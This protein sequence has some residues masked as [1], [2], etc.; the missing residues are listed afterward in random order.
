MSPRS[1]PSGARDC[2]CS[3]TYVA[4]TL[5]GPWASVTSQTKPPALPA[6]VY[7]L[8]GGGDVAVSAKLHGD[9]V[10]GHLCAFGAEELVST[11]LWFCAGEF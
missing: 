3:A 11:D 4:T 6:E 7:A 2:P 8:R 5:R 9:D 1:I 10:T